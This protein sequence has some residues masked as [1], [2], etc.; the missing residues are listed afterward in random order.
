MLQSSDEEIT[1]AFVAAHVD[2][3]QFFFDERCVI[4]LE[5]VERNT[6]SCTRDLKDVLGN[7]RFFM[8]VWIGECSLKLIFPDL[9]DICNQQ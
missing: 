5:G 7:I 8:A 6:D 3:S 2:V 4:I 9:H 1:Q